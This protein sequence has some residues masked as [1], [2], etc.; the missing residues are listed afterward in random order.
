MEGI[1]DDRDVL[2]SYVNLH[3]RANVQHLTLLLN[4][5]WAH[6]AFDLG[7]I[8]CFKIRELVLKVKN[9]A[10]AILKICQAPPRQILKGDAHRKRSHSNIDHFD[11]KRFKI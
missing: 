4:T 8:N 10:Y 6:A 7:P 1:T 5:Y 3:R 9:N 11:P 2:L